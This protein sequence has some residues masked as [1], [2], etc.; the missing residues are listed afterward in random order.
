MREVKLQITANEADQRLDRFLR[1]YLSKAS[2]GLIYKFLRKKDITVNGE[3]VKENYRL[4]IGDI[5]HFNKYVR[6]DDLIEVE[7]PEYYDPEF[8]VVYQDQ[9]LFIVDKPSGLLVH[10]NQK[11]SQNTLNTQVLSYFIDKEIFD[12]E[13][14]LTFTPAP[15]NRLDRNTSGLVMFAKDYQTQ[16][17]LNQMIKERRIDKYYLALVKGKVEEQVQELEGYLSKDEYNNQVKVF[18]EEREDSLPIHT[19][20]RTKKVGEEFTLLE[21]ELITGRSH[22]IRA[23]LASIGHP[24][25]GDPKYG[26]QGINQL[27][28]DKWGLNNQF[29][30][31]YKLVFRDPIK[32]LTYLTQC[33]FEAKL[34]EKLDQIAEKI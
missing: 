24:I 32:P 29:L 26:D 14:E 2:L 9:R 25:V 3:K 1:K 33:Q 18:D 23:H 16:Q 7:V 12:P 20:Y 5:V 11:G 8:D 10:A 19:R 21:V 34:P 31:A 17:A 6:V 4:K 22:Q 15:S 27:V 28:K 30:H 13:E